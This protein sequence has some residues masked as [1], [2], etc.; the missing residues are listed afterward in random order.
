VR[1]AQIVPTLPPTVGGVGGYALVLARGLRDHGWQTTFVAAR[2]E[3]DRLLGAHDVIGLR[4]GERASS[5]VEALERAG[6]ITVLLHYSGYGYAR[7]GAPVWLVRGLRRWKKQNRASRLVVMFHEVYATGRVP[8]SSSFWL[9]PVRKRLAQ[10][11][12]ELA[13]RR[14]TSCARYARLLRRWRPD[15]DDIRVLPVPSNVGEPGEIRPFPERAPTAVVFGQAKRRSDVYRRLADFMPVLERSGIRTLQ[16]VGP[17]LQPEATQALPIGL[18]QHGILDPDELSDLLCQARFGLLHLPAS[19][20][21][22]SGCFAAYAAHGAVCLLSSDGAPAADGL[23]DGQHFI[24]VGSSSPELPDE[25]TLEAVGAHAFRWYSA[26][27]LDSIAEQY[28]QDLR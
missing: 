4:A 13:D 11:L 25:P 9:S 20:L 23:C 2:E 26:H 7:R 22:K 19:L 12:A 14:I 18:H 27:R 6:A 21:A 17:P 28:V 8:W 15:P 10:R 16:D 1:L 24:E 3:G 5:L